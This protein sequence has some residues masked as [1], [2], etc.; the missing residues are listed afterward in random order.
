ML[1][2]HTDSHIDGL[3][4]AVDDHLFSIDGDGSGCGLVQ[5]VE[6][7]HQRTFSCAV[8]SQDR[9]DLSLVDSQMNVVVG[10]K[11]A[12][13]L[14][15]VRHLNGHSVFINVALPFHVYFLLIL[16]NYS[17]PHLDSAVLHLV[18]ASRQIDFQ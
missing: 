7:I 3:L 18:V 11:V 12:E 13:F 9:M 6:N 2:Y 10:G 16:D 1:V 17:E 14:D 15:N 5:T 8:F 4:R